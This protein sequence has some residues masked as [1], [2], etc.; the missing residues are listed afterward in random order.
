[1]S[2]C[3][4]VAILD[5]VASSRTYLDNRP[6][7]VN[8]DFVKYSDADMKMM[9]VGEIGAHFMAILFAVAAWIYLGD[10]SIVLKVPMSFFALMLGWKASLAIVH[11]GYVPDGDSN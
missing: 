6:Y 11:I 8:T 3:S 4:V 2:R 7:E 5:R 10:M 9:A 1:M